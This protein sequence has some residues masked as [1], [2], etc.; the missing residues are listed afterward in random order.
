VRFIELRSIWAI[1]AKKMNNARL[2]YQSFG[3]QLL[4]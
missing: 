3:A 2:M 1:Y 4:F